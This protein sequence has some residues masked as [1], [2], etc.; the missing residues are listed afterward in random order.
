M[1]SRS[2]LRG[3]VVAGRREQ[4]AAGR[5]E[6]VAELVEELAVVLLGRA[7]L[8]YA[9]HRQRERWRELFQELGD[10]GHLRHHLDARGEQAVERGVWF[11]RCQGASQVTV[12]GRG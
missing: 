11:L 7:V 4:V 3:G 5:K 2:G 10:V 6:L 9:D 12:G 8:V 1:G